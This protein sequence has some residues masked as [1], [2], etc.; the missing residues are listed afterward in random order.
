MADAQQRTVCPSGLGNVNGPVVFVASSVCV[1]SQNTP[2]FPLVAGIITAFTF[3]ASIFLSGDMSFAN[4]IGPAPVANKA[5]ASQPPLRQPLSR[6]PQEPAPQLRQSFTVHRPSARSQLDENDALAALESLHFALSEVA[7]GS[8][9]VW[10]RSHG[11]LSG[12]VQI[13]ASF[14]GSDDRICRR[15]IVVF[16]SGGDS[17]RTETIACREASGVW[18][19]EG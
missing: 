1:M 10:H 3:A 17:E 16:T 14:R 8:S 7:D 4:P 5:A 6:R 18:K 11:G 12:V 13:A 15:A 19:I 2:L 9:Y